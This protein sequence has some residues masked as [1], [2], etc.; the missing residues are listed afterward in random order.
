[1]MK[2]LKIGIAAF[3]LC[4]LAVLGACG[5]MGTNNTTTRTTTLTTATTIATTGSLQDGKIS[6]TSVSG[7]NGAIGDL[8]TNA[9]DVVSQ[10]I[11]TT[12]R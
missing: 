7:E 12:T 8:V 5:T 9:S 1:M 6:D 4:A 2:A 10:A 11:P 3:V